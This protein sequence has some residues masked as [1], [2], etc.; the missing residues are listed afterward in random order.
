M[1]KNIRQKYKAHT[2][3]MSKEHMSQC[4]WRK[5]QDVKF[6]AFNFIL[7]DV[8]KHI[9]VRNSWDFNDNECF[10]LFMLNKGDSIFFFRLENYRL[11]GA[12]LRV[13]T[14]PEDNVA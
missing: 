10:M 5:N 9:S 3:S 4:R 6:Y 12:S 14:G 8:Q 11:L 1:T 7:Q 13:V 2:V